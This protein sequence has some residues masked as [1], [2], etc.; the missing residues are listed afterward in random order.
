MQTTQNT[1]ADYVERLSSEP[2]S[3]GDDAAAN[4]SLD[5]LEME[6][7]N[8]LNDLIN[9]E[10]NLRWQSEKLDTKAKELENEGDSG[11][12]DAADQMRAQAGTMIAIAAEISRTITEIKNDPHKKIP[13]R[14]VDGLRASS[15]Q[16][17]GEC[18]EEI[19]HSATV[20]TGA[21]QHRETVRRVVESKASSAKKETASKPKIKPK[22]VKKDKAEEVDVKPHHAAQKEHEEHEHHPKLVKV[23]E[24]AVR[25]VRKVKKAVKGAWHSVCDTAED[26]GEGVSEVF[27]HGVDMVHHGIDMVK[28]AAPVAFVVKTGG[29]IFHAVTHPSETAHRVVSKLAHMKDALVDM[30][31][32]MPWN[33]H[34]H[35]EQSSS[36]ATVG[37]ASALVMLSPVSAPFAM[38][39]FVMD[40]VAEL[41]L[42]KLAFA[43]VDHPPT[44]PSATPLVL[45]SQHPDTIPYLPFLTRS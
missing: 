12:K 11:A 29:K 8:I 27:H 39:H 40:K 9:E 3:E 10:A 41:Q 1:R 7:M 25:V 19:V 36:M 4:P 42:P 21:E 16:A 24:T 31:P 13:R 38:S 6:G 35:A 37:M 22:E 30:L 17:M 34:H 28:H 32:D 5:G 2:P 15:V 14:K 20:H 26:I 33:R 43:H 44:R 45:V 23:Q 18:D